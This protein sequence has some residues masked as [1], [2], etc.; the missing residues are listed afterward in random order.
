MNRP[1]AYIGQSVYEWMFSKPA[2]DAMVA[3]G[4]LAGGVLGS[5]TLANGLACVPT[6]PASLQVVVGAGELY[7][8]APVE[9]TVMGTLPG[10]T[11]HTV[12]KQGVNL[13]PTNLICSPPGTGGQSINYLIQAQY[14]DQDVSVD[15]TTGATNVVLTYY[16]PTNPAV[17]YSGPNNSGL[18]DKTFRKGVVA[19]S[20]K[21]GGAATT[22][23]Q[24]TPSPDAGWVGLY[25][26]T[27]ANGQTQINS[28]N[29]A[30]AAG[31]PILSERLIDKVSIA[32]GDLRWLKIADYLSG[33]DNYAVAT[34]GPATFAATLPVT[35]TLIDGMRVY[36][37]FPTTNTG[38]V[39]PTLNINVL[40]AKTIY[41]TDGSTPLPAALLPLSAELM[42]HTAGG[43]GWSLISAVPITTGV[44]S[45]NG[46]TGSVTLNASDITTS[47]GY[48]PL[49]AAGTV[50]ATAKIN[51]AA[52]ATGHAAIN[53]GV[54]VTPTTLVDSDIWATTAGVFARIAGTSVQLATA[55]G[56]VTSVN[57]HTGAVILNAGDITTSLGYTPVN[58]A[59]DTM[60]G[61][62]NTVGSVAIAGAGMNIPNATAP[63]SPG[64]GDLWG[65]IAGLFY[66][67][68]GAT[69]SLMAGPGGSTTVGDFVAWSNT[70]GTAVADVPAASAADMWGG[71]NNTHPVTA[72]SLASANQELTLTDAAT[73]NWNM[74]Q[75][76]NA[77]WVLG[78]NHALAVSNPV[79]GFNYRLRIIQP[80]S[81]GPYAPP[82]WPASFDW[83]G[84][85]APA[86]SITANARDIITLEWEPSTSK[87]VAQFWSGT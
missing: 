70:T 25:V 51:F 13:D 24:T 9:A 34:G 23:T 57:G 45:I 2:Q 7:Q 53:L 35:P 41:G 33:A 21:A 14:Q 16:D 66:R 56:A 75:G 50:T 38:S 6:G 8:L 28:G 52:S 44:V 86:L 32:T 31:A 37:Q 74:A 1:F 68:N 76:F 61:K 87:F 80:S 48:T 3:L 64:N 85:Q 60:S 81:G 79:A 71:S 11:D 82:V 65:T 46:H 83:G 67:A 5:S 22:G 29:I 4:K 49:D 73:T 78:G 15:P 84:A 26:V 30:T 55:S 39:G 27:V 58:Q 17:P 18:S 40:G 36:V 77:T 69:L 42:Y 43:G 19:L 47:L 59:G 72:A 62:L 20:A 10:D 12:I 63:S 54:G